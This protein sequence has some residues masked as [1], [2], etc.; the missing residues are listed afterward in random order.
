MI[1]KKIY[2]ILLPD[3]DLLHPLDSSHCCCLAKKSSAPSHRP[4]DTLSALNDAS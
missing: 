3:E 2:N 1:S 4:P